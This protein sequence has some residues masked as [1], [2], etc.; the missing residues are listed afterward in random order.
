MIYT[1]TKNTVHT[2][3]TSTW[4][5][6]CTDVAWFHRSLRLESSNTALLS[7]C[8][9]RHVIHLFGLTVDDSGSFSCAAANA[10]GERWKHFT[11]M[12]NRKWITI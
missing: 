3:N 7:T 2:K 8:G 6:L 12:V 4:I 5:E 9:G 1:S 11:I 10:D